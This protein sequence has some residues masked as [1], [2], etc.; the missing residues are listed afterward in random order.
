M[1]VA[2]FVYVALLPPFFADRP[3]LHLQPA[4][5]ALAV[6]GL[7]FCLAL[8]EQASWQNQSAKR[9]SITISM[10]RDWLP[11]LLT[12]VAFQE[13]EFFLP[14]KFDHDFETAWIRQDIKVL[15]DWRLKQLIESLRSVIPVYL[16]FCYLLVY[17]L[18]PFCIAL[19][20]TQHRRSSIDRFLTFYLAGTLLA[21]ALFPFFP[22]QPPRLLFPTVEAPAIT[23]W[24]RR[25]NLFILKKGTIHIGVFPSAH[26]S[27]AFSAAWGMF[28]VFRHKQRIGWMLIVY[29]ASVAVATVYGRYHYSSDVLAGVAVSVVSGLACTWM[30]K[31]TRARSG[32]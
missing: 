5:F 18:G 30:L 9:W 31:R 28:V 10:T 20:Y 22:S 8:A 19:L 7:Q 1:F 4:V 26:V 3:N 13:M 16:E 6:L 23:S 24:V 2:Y 21:Y 12:L 27:S 32:G 15:H 11:I 17:G 25:F 29:A 14:G